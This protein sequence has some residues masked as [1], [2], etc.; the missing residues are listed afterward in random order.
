MFRLTARSLSIFLLLVLLPFHLHAEQKKRFGDYDVHYSV[1]NTTFIT[2]ENAKHYGITRSKNRALV[3]IAIRKNR[4]DGSSTAQR[5]IVTGSSSDLIH[6]TS[7]EFNEV[8]EPDAIY[9]IAQLP[10]NDKEL[11]SFDIKVQPDANISPYSLKFSKT[12]YQ[13]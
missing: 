5:A 6:R 4:P 3:N 13:Q 7:L 12:L 8:I 11:R 9:Y 2:P 10:F 1:L